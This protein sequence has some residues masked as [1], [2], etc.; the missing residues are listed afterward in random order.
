MATVKHATP[1]S[2]T[3]GEHDVVAL[4]DAVDKVE[5]GPGKWPAGTKAAVISDFG[6]HKMLDIVNGQGETLDMPIVPTKKLTLLV[7]HGN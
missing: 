6:D 4:L 7:K 1:A 2:P 3:I 5:C